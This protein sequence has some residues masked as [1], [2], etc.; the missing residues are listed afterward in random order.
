MRHTNLL[1]QVLVLVLF[2][3]AGGCLRA[4]QCLSAAQPNASA[5]RLVGRQL[6]GTLVWS[7]PQG[8]KTGAWVEHAYL[9]FSED[10]SSFLLVTLGAVKVPYRS[11]LG[12]TWNVAESRVL[13]GTYR[14]EAG[15][16]GEVLSVL[17]GTRDGDRLRLSGTSEIGQAPSCELDGT[18]VRDGLLGESAWEVVISHLGELPP[19]ATPSEPVLR[20][21]QGWDYL[22]WMTACEARAGLPH[23]TLVAVN[24]LSGQTVK[25]LRIDPDYIP[26]QTTLEDGTVARGQVRKPSDRRYGR[27]GSWRVAKSPG[28]PCSLLLS[29]LAPAADDLRLSCCPRLGCRVFFAELS[30]NNTKY[31]GLVFRT[32]R[33]EG[34]L[35]QANGRDWTVKHFIMAKEVTACAADECLGELTRDNQ[36]Q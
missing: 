15:P 7:V 13:A 33:T 17:S 31:L 24:F 29:D 26:M 19:E 23:E 2:L 25:A 32:L 22:G 30:V 27:E 8:D 20:D 21:L 35:L 10:S 5:G 6:T 16:S 11:I 9:R 36:R 12:Q 4:P 3:V 28:G 18:A 14:T 1:R 34:R